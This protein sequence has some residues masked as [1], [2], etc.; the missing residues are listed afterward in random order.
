MFDTYSAVIGE[1]AEIEGAHII[2]SVRII[3]INVDC[4]LVNVHLRLYNVFFCK[5]LIWCSNMLSGTT[6][7]E[8]AKLA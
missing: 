7:V 3:S 1:I 4:G 6:K 5:D 8:L 2:N